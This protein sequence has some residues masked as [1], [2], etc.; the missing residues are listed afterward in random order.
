MP[1]TGWG[2]SNLKPVTSIAAGALA[3][4]VLEVLVTTPTLSQLSGLFH[5]PSIFVNALIDPSKPLIPDKVAATAASPSQTS[6]GPA[7]P[8]LQ[9]Q[10][11]K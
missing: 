4:I 8:N 5:Y 2:W 11:K 10:L 3:L 7:S 6:A 9:N 1:S